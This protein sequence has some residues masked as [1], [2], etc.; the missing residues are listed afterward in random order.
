MV[1]IERMEDMVLFTDETNG[2]GFHL[3]LYRLELNKLRSSLKMDDETIQKIYDRMLRYEILVWDPEKKK[4]FRQ[5]V[6]KHR[7]NKPIV[8]QQDTSV[9]D[10]IDALGR[11]GSE[12]I[13]SLYEDLR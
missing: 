12:M 11:T 6:P 8:I 3:G 4:L 2:T 7:A 13:D 10:T 1:K 5:H 9:N